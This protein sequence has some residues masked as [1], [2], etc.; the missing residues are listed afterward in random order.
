MGH[1][2]TEQLLKDPYFGYLVISRDVSTGALDLLGTAWHATQ[3]AA[4]AAILA[5]TPQATIEY[6]IVKCD[7]LSVMLDTVA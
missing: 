6:M 4:K 7:V 5:A 3:A 1:T 2:F